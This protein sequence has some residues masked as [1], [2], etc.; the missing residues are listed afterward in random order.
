MFA[1]LLTLLALAVVVLVPA[2]QSARSAAPAA[3]SARS[4]VPSARSAHSAAPSGLRAFLLRVDDFPGR[5]S[6]PRTPAFAWEP[7]D[8]AVSYD[9]QLA[10]SRK[11]DDRT[12]VWS[13]DSRAKPLRVPAV[14]IPIALPWMTG[15]PSALYIR[16]RARTAT[17]V[18][19][20]SSPWGFNMQWVGDGKPEKLPD[21]PGLIRWKPV[22]GATA[23]QVWFEPQTPPGKLI[24]TTANVA[25]ER[26]YY[27]S[28]LAQPPVFDTPFV[29]WRVR[30]VRT[31]YGAMPNGLPAVSY[32]PWSATYVSALWTVSTG[33]LTP[34]Q[35]ASDILTD[36][37]G[38][39]AH[40]L[41][42]GYSFGGDTATN[43]AVGR[44]FRVYVATDRQCVNG[45]FTG[46][47]VG[48]PGY[49]PRV[50]LAGPPDAGNQPGTAADGEP[51]TPTEASGAAGT[52]G[53]SGTAGA[54]PGGG[55]SATPPGSAT[56]GPAIDLWDLGRANARYWWTVVPVTTTAGG[57]GTATTTTTTTTTT[58]PATTITPGTS[59]GSG[60]A[61]AASEYQ[62]LQS[63][64]DACEAG[65]VMRFVK[66]T[67]PVV[68]SATLPFVSGL[69]PLGDLVAARTMQPSFYRAPLVAWEPVPGATAYELQWSKTRTPWRPASKT[70]VYTA[71]TSALLDDLGP[72]TWY[73]RIRG[74]DPYMP[75]PIKQMTWSTPQRLK[76]TKPRFVIEDGS[77][78]TR[79][80]KR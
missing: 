25:D 53:S 45:V 36:D 4:A 9:F 39:L 12:I 65:R 3:Q 43:G 41:T 56:S 30:A 8:G 66:T 74:I 62:D 28:A 35:T 73:Y 79:R 22:E 11:I 5:T 59:S 42:P 75:G 38:T 18:T 34:V 7:Y 76:L 26:D 48:S 40:T 60:A 10:T 64:Q 71:G 13:T 46:A 63:P 6:F 1:R 51:V 49:A 31:L 70:P 24:W 78:T 61:N 50:V 68:T 80:V 55:T 33:W 54:T 15:H 16:V 27:P 2:A 77:V 52:S 17:G 47:V 32:G 20:W 14:T 19:R 37:T 67:A 23:Y 29:N 21:G 57:S 58:T 69:S 44:L 72:G